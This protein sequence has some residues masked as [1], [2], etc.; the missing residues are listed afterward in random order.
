MNIFA[1]GAYGKTGIAALE[2]L[3]QSDLVTKIAVA[4]RNLEKAEKAAAQIGEKA[5]PLYADGTDE[6]K[7]SSLSKGYD[8]IINAANNKVV[9]PAIRAAI[10][11]QIHYCDMA[12]GDIL[13][14][15][16]IVFTSHGDKHKVERSLEASHQRRRQHLQRLP[17]LRALWL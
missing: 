2:L 15:E 5:V 8:M 10:Q 9:L 17:R 3:A 11:N 6:E 16:W 4:G 13:E 1:L 7:L 14:R 12:W